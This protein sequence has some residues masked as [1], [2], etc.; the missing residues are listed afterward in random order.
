[1]KTILDLRNKA[2]FYGIIV[3][4]T[5]DASH[6]EQNVLIMRSVFQNKETKLFK[7]CERFF[8]FMNFNRKTGVAK[9]EE[10]LTTLKNLQVPLEDC[11]AQGYDNSSNM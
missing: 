7:I 11:H 5:P 1:M 3:D 6:Q 4:A 8:E 2:I 10:I 9:T